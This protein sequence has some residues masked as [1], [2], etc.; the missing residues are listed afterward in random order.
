MKRV[1]V[2]LVLNMAFVVGSVPLAAQKTAASGT[3]PLPAQILTAKK[4]FVSY[5]GGESNSRLAGYSGGTDRTYNQFYASLKTWGHYDLVPTP[6]EAELVFEISFTNPLVG[7]SVWGGATTNGTSGGVS[8]TSY[9]DP[10]LRVTILDLKTRIVLWAL[11]EHVEFA[12]LQGNRD[13]NFDQAM[14]ALIND[15]A[16]LAGRPPALAATARKNDRDHGADQ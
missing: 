2:A 6:A 1:A 3:A 4:V 9:T 11:V 16:K 15:I 7:A 8:S 12:R 13:K 5:A 14:V 10:Q